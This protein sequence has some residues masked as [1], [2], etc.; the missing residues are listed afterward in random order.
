MFLNHLTKFFKPLKISLEN[1]STSESKNVDN[2]SI[3][4]K[5]NFETIPT[6]TMTNKICRIK[7]RISL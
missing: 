2:Q 7:S 6:D 1:K 3:W 5:I 4:K